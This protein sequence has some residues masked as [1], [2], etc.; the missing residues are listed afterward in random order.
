MTAS[1]PDAWPKADHAGGD[2]GPL[3][4]RPSQMR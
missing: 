3:A 1:V 2:C 4:L